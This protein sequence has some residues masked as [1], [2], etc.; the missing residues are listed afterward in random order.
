MSLCPKASCPLCE[1][2]EKTFLE[3]R[4]VQVFCSLFEILRGK[5]SKTRLASRLSC[6][7]QPVLS[8]GHFRS[9]HR[10]T[11]ASWFLILRSPPHPQPT[12]LQH[13]THLRN[14]PELAIVQTR[15]TELKTQ[16]HDLMHRF[17]CG[18][19]FSSP[20][21]IYLISARF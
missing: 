14:E 12:W 10:L 4:W 18:V 17:F 5:L 3:G 19:F 6:F 1:E 8:P 20:K 2:E 7:P 15:A 21:K 11:D 16:L 9:C 13:H